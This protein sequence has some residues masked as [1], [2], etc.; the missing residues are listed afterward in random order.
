MALAVDLL[1]RR[2]ESTKTL[3]YLDQSTLSNLACDPDFY[4]LR[5]MLVENVK[6][7]RLL[8]PWSMDHHSETFDAKRW[9]EIR[10]LGDELS[11]G[12]RLRR[13][14]CHHPGRMGPPPLAAQLSLYVCRRTA[15][16][17]SQTGEERGF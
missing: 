16:R 1:R 10:K 15:Y 17:G 7:D 2:P 14:S 9:E 3:I 6:E 12:I 11:M 8:C 13:G 5:D 4:E